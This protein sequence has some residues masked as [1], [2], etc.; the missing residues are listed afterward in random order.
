MIFVIE[1]YIKKQNKMKR[2]IEEEKNCLEYVSKHVIFSV[3]SELYLF[4][5][6]KGP[7][8]EY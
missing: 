8:V 4:A 3:F 5:E 7:K 6:L 2:K 1:K